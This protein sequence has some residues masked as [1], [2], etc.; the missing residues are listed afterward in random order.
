MALPIFPFGRKFLYA[1]SHNTNHKHDTNI[2][3]DAAL[4]SAVLKECVL[5]SSLEICTCQAATGRTPSPFQVKQDGLAE[6]CYL[7]SW[8]EH[9]W[10]GLCITNPSTC[11]AGQQHTYLQAVAVSAFINN[12]R[13][14]CLTN[15]SKLDK[16]L[17]F[18]LTS[19]KWTE[20]RQCE[21]PHTTVIIS[22]IR[23]VPVLQSQ[24]AI[25]KLEQQVVQVNCFR[26]MIMTYTLESI[27]VWNIYETLLLFHL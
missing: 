15:L 5:S 23:L 17:V 11:T 13:T 16:T 6:T 21:K 25:H 27:L 2:Q 14:G 4:L 1:F 8:G 9:G 26:D 19:F 18:P 7:N 12:T 20:R 22:M 24:F 3:G 10:Q